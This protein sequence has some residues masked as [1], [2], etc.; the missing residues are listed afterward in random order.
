MATEADR[1]NESYEANRA[2]LEAEHKGKFLLITGGRLAGVYDSLDA[3][4]NAIKA[5]SPRPIHAIL[6][7]AGEDTRQFGEWLAGSFEP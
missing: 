5:L 2:E 1:K 6:T 4:G 7:K 3:A